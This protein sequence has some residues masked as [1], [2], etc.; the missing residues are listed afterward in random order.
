MDIL[1]SCP[2]YI[3]ERSCFAQRSFSREYAPLA[4]PQSELPQPQ[5]QLCHLPP[6]GC[7]GALLVP[8]HVIIRTCSRLYAMVPRIERSRS[9]WVPHTFNGRKIRRRII[10]CK[11]RNR[12]QQSGVR[13]GATITVAAMR[14]GLGREPSKLKL[15]RTPLRPFTSR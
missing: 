5:P 8:P 3:D 10:R 1:S 4:Q 6:S 2:R 7:M 9:V 15:R 12:W 13:G 14:P 11:I